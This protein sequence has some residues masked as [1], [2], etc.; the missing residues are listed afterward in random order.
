MTIVAVN[1]ITLALTAAGWERRV[2][3]KSVGD[4]HGFGERRPLL[5]SSQG[6]H[7]ADLT[8]TNPPRR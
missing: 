5:S 6:R 1:F 3:E 4:T 8:Y 7:R 2:R